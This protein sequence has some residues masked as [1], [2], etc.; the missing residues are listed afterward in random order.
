[1]HDRMNPLLSEVVRDDGP[2]P[3][4][5]PPGFPPA[6]LVQQDAANRPWTRPQPENQEKPRG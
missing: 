2:T 5:L 6:A 4:P 1:M 3:P